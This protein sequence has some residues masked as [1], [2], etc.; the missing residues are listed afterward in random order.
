MKDNINTKIIGE[1]IT[2]VPY[3]KE[4]VK[5][6]HLWMQDEE[7]LQATASEKLTLEEEYENQISWTNVEM[8]TLTS[9]FCLI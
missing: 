1:R 8:I 2:L 6:Y 4:H 3:R 7:I 9:I 5:K